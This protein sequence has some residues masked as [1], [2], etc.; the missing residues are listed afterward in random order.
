MDRGPIECWQN[1]V[2]ETTLDYINLKDFNKK[3]EY[4]PENMHSTFVTFYQESFCK[5]KSSKSGL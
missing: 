4:R 5:A 2:V 3:S 1:L